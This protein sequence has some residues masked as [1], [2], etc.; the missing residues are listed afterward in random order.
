MRI[1]SYNIHKGIGGRDRL[2]R[3]ERVLE[4]I[5]GE[6][7]D[8]LCLQE[9]DRNVR[10]SRHHDQ[11][12]MLQDATELEHAAYQFNH[13]VRD[14]GYGNLILSRWPILR[15]HNISVRYKGRKNRRAQ[16]VVL[17]TPQG[18]LRLVNWHL[19]L[20]ERERQWQVA[21]LLEHETFV[22]CG[23]RATIV[24]GDSNDWRNTLESGAFDG[25]GLVQMTA[26]PL[27]YRS[28]PA[29]MPI[30][31]LDKAFACGRVRLEDVQVI[32]NTLTRKASDHLPLVIDFAL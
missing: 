23:G 14:G 32:S 21:R 11:P 13:R 12:K 29:Y 19:G 22:E 4:V 10:R 16:L 31:A 20:S 28:F 18:E 24:A 1:L 25:H 9:V 30:G 6:Q 26:P 3:P 27:K 15:R 2:Y 17:D 7:P 5:R 8:I